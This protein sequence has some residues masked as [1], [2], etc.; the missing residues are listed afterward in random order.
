MRKT[1][2]LAGLAAL[3]ATPALAQHQACLR[4]NQ[5]YNWQVINNRTLVVEDFHHQK[6][7]VNLMGYCPN[8]AFK[9]SVGFKTIGG[10]QLSC[11]STGD[12]VLVHDPVTGGPCP[13]RSIVPYLSPGHRGANRPDYENY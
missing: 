1:I 8:L 10:T 11:L 3:I 12:E 6:F 4:V 5:I 2:L 7:R 9:E 13:I